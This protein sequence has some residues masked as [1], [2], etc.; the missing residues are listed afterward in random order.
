MKATPPSCRSQQVFSLWAKSAFHHSSVRLP[1]PYRRSPPTKDAFGRTP[2]TSH[3]SLKY[4][5]DS[6]IGV[7]NLP[8][9]TENN[10]LH[11][12]YHGY[13][14]NHTTHVEGLCLTLITVTSRTNIIRFEHLRPHPRRAREVTTACSRTNTRRSR[15]SQPSH[16]NTQQR[17]QP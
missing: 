9:P 7:L 13:R 15:C 5:P 12:A 8:S 2:R 17:C 16:P 3:Y 6:S 4:L 1:C 11:K 14:R 10:Y